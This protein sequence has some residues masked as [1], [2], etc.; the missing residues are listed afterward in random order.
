MGASSGAVSI[1]QE[2]VR[3]LR[4]QAEPMNHSYNHSE[5]P[6]VAAV[7]RNSAFAFGQVAFDALLLLF[8][9]LGEIT[10]RITH[11]SPGVAREW[12]AFVAWSQ[13][14]AVCCLVNCLL[15]APN[16]LPERRGQ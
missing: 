7:A 14:V 15:A 2:L 11:W 4:R 10:G 13:C 5:G 16:C 8:G 3:G 6:I 1:S 9:K 12:F